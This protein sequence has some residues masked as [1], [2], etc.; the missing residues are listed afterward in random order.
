M[1]QD[2]L[3]RKL[4]AILS[5][6][7]EGYSRLMRDD[8]EATICRLTDYRT[9]MTTLIEQYRGRVVDAPGDNLLAE[10][11]SVVDAVN[12]AVE[13]QRELAERN[14]ELPENCQ[15]QFRIGVNLGDVIEDGERIY[16]DGVNI[17]ARMER[18][19]EPGGICISGTVYDSIVINL[20][21]EYE[22]LG[23]QA[24]KNIPELI[25]SYR[26]LSH[27]GAAAHRVVKVKRDLQKKWRNST[28]AAVAILIVAIGAGG[29][30]Y[31]F[32][33]SSKPT[34]EV[35]SQENMAF[36]LPDRPSIAVLPFVNMGGDTEQEYFIDG[37]TEDIITDLSRLSGLFVISRSSTFAYKGKS[38]K[39]KQVAEELGVRYVIEGSVRKSGDKVRINAQLIDAVTGRHLWAERYDRDYKDI[40]VLQDDITQ[41]IV[42]T[43]D[44]EVFEAEMERI[45]RIPTENLTAYESELRG[46]AYIR[47][48]KKSTNAQAQQMFERAIE[49]DPGYAGPYVGLGWT[50]LLEWLWGWSSDPQKMRRAF[51]LAQ[52]AI[53]LDDSHADAYMLIAM[54]YLWKDRQH[55]QAIA[56]AQTAIALD[57]NN[58]GGY[59]VLAEASKFGGR[60][61]EVIE[62]M[63]KAMRLNP[64]YPSS[65]LFQSGSSYY[66]MGRYQE[67]LV[68]LKRAATR[69]PNHM[70]TRQYMTAIYT[71][72]GRE[73]EAKAEMAEVLRISPDHSLEEMAKYPYK[74]P[75]YLE[76]LRGHMRKA[77]LK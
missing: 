61:A 47:I 26:V 10:F 73:E 29:I 71:E 34:I 70:P 74:D 12:C 18:L 55:E 31:F 65:Y 23:E 56:A 24:V 64:R 48:Y 30:W 51:E 54:V 27:P 36:P 15:M 13:I 67:A 41:K 5:A 38:P 66:Y 19:A 76:R 6:D 43:L 52:M 44:V 40:F 20:G 17:A 77:G 7:V 37:I 50:Y 25:R 22:Y 75:A 1:A 53:N 62:L 21:L 42:M 32:M 57:P 60:P 58:A 28:L 63:E 72:L 46:V 4:S 68:L 8:E 3:K 49:L 33:R 16:G 35:A 2:T 11:G 69:R 59:S 39:I 45:R 9:A 14:A